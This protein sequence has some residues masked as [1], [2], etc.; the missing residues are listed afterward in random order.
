MAAALDDYQPV[1]V[2]HLDQLTERLQAPVHLDIDL[3]DGG[4]ILR[5]E[6]RRLMKGMTQR[7]MEHMDRTMPPI[8]TDE[9][10]REYADYSAPEFRTQ[11]KADERQGKALAVWLAFPVL[12]GDLPADLGVDEIAAVLDQKLTDVIIDAAWDRLSAAER[13]VG[14]AVDFT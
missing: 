13:V 7:V 6:G 1:T 14:K 5:I 2:T 9:Q 10:G 8:K 12:R 3:C 4:P 11:R